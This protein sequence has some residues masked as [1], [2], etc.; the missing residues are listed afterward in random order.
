MNNTVG[1]VLLGAASVP[2]IM[3]WDL[4]R[5]GL[6]RVSVAS[7]EAVKVAK[8]AHGAVKKAQFMIAQAPPEEATASRNRRQR[9]SRRPMPLQPGSAR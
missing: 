7:D 6:D 8:E 9:L 3:G 2:G 4:S 1:Y 5:R